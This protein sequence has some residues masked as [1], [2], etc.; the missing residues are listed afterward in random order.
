MAFGKKLFWELK[1]LDDCFMMRNF[2]CVM[3]PARAAVN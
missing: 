3:L 1:I 2:D